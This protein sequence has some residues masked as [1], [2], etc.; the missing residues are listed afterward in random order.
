MDDWGGIIKIPSRSFPEGGEEEKVQQ[1]VAE[2]MK[3]AGARVR[4]FEA[5][6]IPGC[7]EHPLWCGP[8]RNYK[9]RPTVAGEFGPENAPALIVM[10]H[11]DT[12]P[13][14]RP[15][16]WKVDPFCGEIKNGK[17]YGLGSGDD[18]WGVAA[19]LAIMRAIAASG[20]T[21]EK[22]LIFIST[23]DEENGVGNGLILLMLAGIRAEAALYLDGCQKEVAI[24]NCGGS[25]LYL[26]PLSKI[27]PERFNNHADLL[28][29]ACKKTSRERIPL[30]DMPFFKQWQDADK[31]FVFYQ[32]QDSR[33]PFFLIAFYM[34]DGETKESVRKQLENM[35]TQAL[36]ADISLYALSYRN[37]WFEPSVIPADTPLIGYLTKASGE[38]IRQKPTIKILGKQDSFVFRNYAKIP[39]ISFGVSRF[40]K[41]GHHQPNESVFVEDGWDACRI[42]YRTVYNWLKG[43]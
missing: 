2:K 7:L 3:A 8:E 9:A 41:E 11:S 30:F 34:P 42:A 12:V 32:R 24:G 23:M 10:A 15:E 33:G 20:K 5:A 4:T 43:G 25:N 35:I 39:T 16:E 26:R 14:L 1:F 6:D 28:E 22:R 18:K 19:M 31:S 37:P 40:G 17:I 27:D 29:N 38:E 21:P 13:I 36:G